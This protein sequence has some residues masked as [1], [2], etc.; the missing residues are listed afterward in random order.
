MGNLQ[1]VCTENMKRISKRKILSLKQKTLNIKQVCHQCIKNFV[2]RV[3]ILSLT[4]KSVL[5]TK[6]DA[7]CN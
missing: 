5:A 6:T 3:K 7:N 2:N 1:P 4:D